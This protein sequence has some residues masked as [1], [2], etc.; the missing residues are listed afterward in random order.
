MARRA[1]A[2]PQVDVRAAQLVNLRVLRAPRATSAAGALELLRKRGAETLVAAGQR[3]L[4]FRDD[5]ARAVSLGLPTIPAGELETAVPVV[6]AGASEIA[7]RRLLRGGARAVLV[8]DRLTAIGAVGS[9]ALG[10]RSGEGPSLAAL[11]HASLSPEARALLAEV[12][13]LAAAAG[14]RAFL[15]GGIVRD[16]LLARRASAAST[17]RPGEVRRDLDVVIEGSAVAIARRLARTAGGTLR[18]HGAFGTASL[19]GLPA[20]RIDIATA[21]AERYPVPGALPQVRPG[22]ILDDLRRRDFGMNAMAVELQSGAFALLDPLG[23]QEDIRHRRLRVLHPLSFVE[24]PTRIFRA[25]RY[26][27]RLGISLDRGSRRARALALGLVPYPA[28]SGQRI[29][30]EIAHILDEA[31][32]V[33]ALG[34]LGRAG[35]F[36]LVDSRLRFTRATADRLTRLPAALAWMRDRGVSA[37]R[38]ELAVLAIIGDQTPEVVVAALRRLGFAGEPLARLR[39]AQADVPSLIA[40]LPAVRPASRRAEMLR[41]RAPVELGWA[42]LLGGPA[43]RSALDWYVERAAE[44]R[45]ELRA[46]DLVALG[47]PAGPAIGTTLRR[48]RDARLDGAAG[49][50]DDEAALVRAWLEEAQSTARKER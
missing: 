21:R 15:T 13:R 40:R 6:L 32:A 22:T 45:S 33:P 17:A 28:L 19:D 39:R 48:L 43:A 7:V 29:V 49:S 44:A 3:G 24:D 34:S 20:G 25:A 23:G 27:A 38:Q 41:D 35:A 1:H 9:S 30:A 26:A 14:A 2:Y 50:R 18:I 12:G 11:L 16:M 4:I 42:W 10:S 5:L 37:S 46:D 36:R 47:I 8:M 31:T